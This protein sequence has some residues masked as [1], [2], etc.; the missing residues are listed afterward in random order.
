M[1][2]KYV[3]FSPHLHYGGIK[4]NIQ[5][6]TYFKR[7][8]RERKLSENSINSYFM[9]LNDY[10][11]FHQMSLENLL[12]EADKEEEDGIRWKKRTLKRR[13][14]EYRTYLVE[15]FKKNTVKT[16]FNQIKAFYRHFEI[17]IL[18]LP[19]ISH[20]T[21][22]VSE[23]ITY[24]DMLT[25]EIIEDALNF[26]DPM[27][28]AIILLGVSSGMGRSEIR[29]LTIN[30]FF[31]ACQEECNSDDEIKDTLQRMYRSKELYV[32]TFKLLRQKVRE[33]YYTF[34]THEFV[35]ATV[36]HLITVPQELH[37]NEPLFNI[38]EERFNERYKVLNDVLGLGKVGSFRKF[39]SHMVR[40]YNAT[41]LKN[42]SNAMS[43]EDIDFLQGRSRG[44]VRE[45]YMKEN[46]LVLKEKYISAMNNVLIYHESKII[47]EQQS[48]IQQLSEE[49]DGIYRLL[50]KFNID[51][52]AL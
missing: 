19:F 25:R 28:K 45:L 2:M 26:A 8:C 12:E 17:E 46:P 43:E 11:K 36:K 38:T 16:R 48:K 31:V 44:T 50:D 18:K 34:A 42:G 4:M 13:L 40:K 33:Y 49:L 30:D 3:V 24:D 29:S 23:P 7:F 51:M 10:C 37:L 32:P 15:N 27:M 22:I 6:S 47:S 9:S 35:E 39:R 52:E 21:Y 5:E 41:A 1:L 20:K 14:V